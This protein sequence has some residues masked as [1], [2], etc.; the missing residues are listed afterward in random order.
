MY[1]LVIV[2]DEALIREGLRAHIDWAALGFEVVACFEDGKDAIDYLQSNQVDVMLTDIKM[3][4][5]SGLDLAEYINRYKADI[6]TVIISG[7]QEFEFA[8]K[9]MQLGVVDYILK[10]TKMIE[11]T[12]VFSALRNKL[13]VEKQNLETTRKNEQRFDELIGLLKEQLFADLLLGSFRSTTEIDRRFKALYGK[14]NGSTYGC[15]V[16]NLALEDYSDFIEKQWGYGKDRFKSALE[17]VMETGPGEILHFPVLE[18]DGRIEL[19]SIAMREMDRGELRTFVDHRL[20]EV[21]KYLQEL[22]GLRMRIDHTEDYESI[23]ALALR[24]VDD[25]NQSIPDAESTSLDPNPR[26][27]V[28]LEEQKAGFVSHMNSGEVEMSCNLL[29]SMLDGM[30]NQSVEKIRAF[31]I[32]LFNEVLSSLHDAIPGLHRFQSERLS[33]DTLQAL[34][35]LEA[36]RRW[37]RE[38]ATRLV[39]LISTHQAGFAKVRIRKAIEYIETNY[40]KDISLADVAASLYIN[41]VYFC[42]YFKQETG[43]NF[44]QYLTEV[45]MEKAKELMRN[46]RLKS[47]EIGERVGY[48]NSKYFMRVF[49]QYTGKTTMEYQWGLSREKDSHHET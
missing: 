20:E 36:W 48:R 29:D 46:S 31:S 5:V 44:S 11:I 16:A 4:E 38:T 28:I 23:H 45:R 27:H 12:R 9:A 41:P 37:G 15:C 7:Y 47:Y 40:S 25:R 42:R 8:K 2:D 1:K 14:W 33:Q 26:N 49:K 35:G 10:P 3:A 22:F 30:Q 17:N 19:I 39:G 43:E 13:D 18:P 24:S 6:S 21:G 34:D 32:D